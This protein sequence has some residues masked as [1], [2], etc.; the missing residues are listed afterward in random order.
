MIF[1][2]KLQAGGWPAMLALLASTSPVVAQEKTPV[3]L[4]TVVIRGGY[5]EARGDFDGY[6]AGLTASATKF[7]TPLLEIPQAINVIGRDEIESRTSSRLS[8]VLRYAPGVTVESDGVDSRFDSISIRGFNTE[9]ATWLDGMPYQAGASLGSGN[10]WTIPQID[11]FMLERVEILKGPSSSLYGQLPPGGLINQLSKRPSD[12]AETVLQAELDGFGKAGIAIDKTG[13]INETLSYRIIAKAHETGAR[14]EEGDRRR[15]LLAPSL[16]ML[17][18][19]GKLTLAGLLQRD[20]G[21]IEYAWLPAYGT[22]WSNPNG[23]I[24]RDFFAGDPD[25]NR[26][27][28]DQ[29]MLGYEYETPLTGSLTLRHALRWSRVKSDLEMVQSDLWFDQIADWDGRTMERYAVKA[30]GTT[31]SIVSD[32]SLSWDIDAGAARHQIVAGI[33]YAR[34]TFDA[35]RLSGDAPALDLYAPVYGAGGIG[36][37]EL[38]S[39]VVSTLIQIGLYA[40]DQVEFGNWRLIAGLR[41]DRAKSRAEIERSR[42]NEVVE[43]SDSATSG[44]VGLLYVFENG[45]APYL[46]YGT[47]F[48]PVIGTDFGGTPF[49]P[50]KGKQVEFGMRYAPS[51]NLLWTAAVFDIRQTNRLT[52]DPV[53]GWPDQVQTGEVRSRGFETELKADFDNG[54]SLTAGYAYTDAKVSK[55]EIPDEQGKQLIFTPRHQASLWADYTVQTGALTDWTFGAGLR[56]TGASRGGDI[57]TPGGYAG[58]K[59]PGYTLL[60]ARVEMPLSQWHENATLNLSVNNLTDKHHV[61]GCGAVWTCGYGYGRT[62]NLTLKARF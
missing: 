14:V 42:G 46:S 32:T 35:T 30:T 15:F 59:I 48:Q 53:N 45:F 1:L 57:E 18:G 55:S 62:S 24:G 22:L 5:E 37:F 61:S 39:N 47:S 3:V 8:E 7:G 20:R 4:D 26:Y 13:S 40:Q 16:A 60:D 52:D 12:Q 21:G 9:N 50:M 10:N 6:L 51:D 54:W 36:N 41:H 56:H 27:D 29:A 58:M 23:R 17:L 11:P 33:D 31:D 25:F 49:K 34:S 28:R 38:L 43:Q 19:E 2:R 44:R